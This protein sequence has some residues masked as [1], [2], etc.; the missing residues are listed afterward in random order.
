MKTYVNIMP[1]NPTLIG[2][3]GALALPCCFE[4]QDAS[5]L[6]CNS[7]VSC[8]QMFRHCEQGLGS[9]LTLSTEFTDF[10]F[11]FSRLV[12]VGNGYFG[13]VEQFQ[14]PCHNRAGCSNVF[15]PGLYHWNRCRW[16]CEKLNLEEGS[17]KHRSTHGDSLF[18]PYPA[19]HR[20][21]SIPYDSSSSILRLGLASWAFCQCCWHELLLCFASTWFCQ[22][23]E[24]TTYQVPSFAFV[25]LSPQLKRQTL[26]EEYRSPHGKLMKIT[27]FSISSCCKWV[28]KSLDH[29][30]WPWVRRHYQACCS[31]SPAIMWSPMRLTGISLYPKSK[32]LY[33]WARKGGWHGV[34]ILWCMFR[35][36]HFHA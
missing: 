18:A 35:F 30:C 6:R 20:W 23:H 28:S 19:L 29:F 12:W 25:L 15:A 14:I 5:S 34:T 13:K 11:L 7:S 24:F 31:W 16:C 21:F 1:L 17:M 22:L 33:H 2:K 10:L 27:D 9:L 32:A 8:L 26:Q 3:F 36:M 4:D